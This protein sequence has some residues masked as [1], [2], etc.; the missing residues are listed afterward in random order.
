M[1]ESTDGVPAT[2]RTTL[3]DRVQELRLTG[4]VEG[5]SA[6]AGVT[7]WL[8]WVLC[9]FLAVGWAGFAIKYYVSARPKADES[10]SAAGK[11]G[12]SG[13]KPSITDT[14]ALEV[15]GYLIPT[16]QISI[17]PID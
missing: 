2:G 12:S 6:K 14:V 1:N 15:K 3:T 16:Q 13:P 4:T 11:A 8:P 9:A 17:S 10:T 5:S 7:S